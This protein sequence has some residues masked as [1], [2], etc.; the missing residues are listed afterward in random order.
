MYDVNKIEIITVEATSYCNARCPQCDR[1]DLKNNTIVPLKH[2]SIETIKKINKSSFPGLKTLRFEGNCG[3]ILNH[4]DALE[5]SQCFDDID[6]VI[7]VTNASVRNPEYFEKL[8]KVKN[9]KIMFSIDGLE[10][11]NHLYRQNTDFQKIIKNANAF[12]AAGGYAIWKFIIFEHNQHQL[13]DVKKTAYDLG[14]KEFT[15]IHSDRSWYQG[16][17][18]PV[19]NK[20]VYQFDLKPSSYVVENNEKL[21]SDYTNLTED[22]LHKF[23]NLKLPI[24]CSW[25]DTKETFIEYNGNV[26][27][28]CMLSNDFWNNNGN[29]KFL[30][31]LL[32][33]KDSINL[34][35][36]T[37]DEIF[38]SDFYVNKLPQSLEK[39]PMMKCVQYCGK[40]L[41]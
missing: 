18:W 32:K 2:L 17:S 25:H 19:Y 21:P 16:N 9:L 1:F 33:D 23:K 8:A 35:Y 3:D 13:E 39:K 22:L 28:C 24:K 20:N 10:D 5:I 6:E 11:T 30:F 37:V 36:H 29:S 40:I 15:Y 31:S 27:P 26:L 34:N 12:I 14:F 41:K 38:K 7:F 4:P